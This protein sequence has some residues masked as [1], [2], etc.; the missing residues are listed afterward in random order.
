M[1][2]HENEKSH[3]LE[4]ERLRTLIE[5]AEKKYIDTGKL[6]TLFLKPAVVVAKLI[7]GY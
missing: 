4:E 2:W 7:A 3:L 1:K 6:V 5:L